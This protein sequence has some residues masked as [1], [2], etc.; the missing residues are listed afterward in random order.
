M[1]Y[2]N[3]LKFKN[4]KIKL[5]QIVNIVKKVIKKNCSNNS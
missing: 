4:I 5:H 3:N 1:T 2:H